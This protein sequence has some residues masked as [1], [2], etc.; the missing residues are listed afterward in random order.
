MSPTRKNFLQKKKKK[1]I[2]MNDRQM[3]RTSSAEEREAN[4]NQ[5]CL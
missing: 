1:N 4:V 2:E 5:L 3:V